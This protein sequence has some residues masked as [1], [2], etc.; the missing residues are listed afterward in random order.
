MET[1][2]IWIIALFGWA[3]FNIL[4]FYIEKNKSDEQ[5]IEFNYRHFADTHWDNWFVTLFFAVPIVY[6]GPEI[7]QGIMELT[8]WDIKWNMIFYAGPGIFVEILVWG[9]KEINKKLS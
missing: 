4:V 9:L 2:E 3:G 8:G 5:D 7:H 6:Y 1:L